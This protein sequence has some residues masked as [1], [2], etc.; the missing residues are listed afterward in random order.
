ML[1]ITST[2]YPMGTFLFPSKGTL[3]F[4]ADSGNL[5][6]DLFLK[7]RSGNFKSLNVASAFSCR[8]FHD[9]FINFFKLLVGAVKHID[10]RSEVIPHFF[11]IVFV[12]D[13]V[14]V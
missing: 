9:I 4:P 10:G 6:K 1:E 2:K 8:N 3:S 12:T 7:H 11:Q 5:G 14:A 13:E